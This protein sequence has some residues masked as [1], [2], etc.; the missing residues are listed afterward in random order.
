MSLVWNWVRRK[1]MICFQILRYKFLRLDK[2]INYCAHL[3]N[4]GEDCIKMSIFLYDKISF[5]WSF[6]S[7]LPNNK[8]RLESNITYLHSIICISFLRQCYLM[9]KNMYLVQ[10]WQ[11]RVK[12]IKPNR[13][14]NMIAEKWSIQKRRG[15]IIGYPSLWQVRAWTPKT[16]K[17]KINQAHIYTYFIHLIFGRV[18]DHE[19]IVMNAWA[20][21]HKLAGKLAMKLWL[22]HI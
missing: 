17:F 4:V 14:Y 19:I 18:S 13:K 3:V 7:L 12:M 22:G 9:Y 20:R 2:V 15:L 16:P 8:I 11:E 6:Y 10:E 5:I 1:W 21:P